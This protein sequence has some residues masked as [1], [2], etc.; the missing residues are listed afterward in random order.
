ML[1]SEHLFFYHLVFSVCGCCDRI[2]ILFFAYL[3]KIRSQ[4]KSSCMGNWQYG[5]QLISILTACLTIIEPTNDYQT[6]GWTVA[7]TL[8]EAEGG[9]AAAARGCGAASGRGSTPR[10]TSTSCSNNRTPRKIIGTQVKFLD[11]YYE[12][13]STR[14]FLHTQVY[15]IQ[16]F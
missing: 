11:I 13:L 16:V 5:Q 6:K 8:V 10:S 3:F 1:L 12:Y 15:F 14:W 7:S 4:R 2:S 9:A